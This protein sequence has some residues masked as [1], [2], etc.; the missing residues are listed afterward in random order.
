MYRV[1]INS[2]MTTTPILTAI[3]V[4]EE[5]M[6]GETSQVTSWRDGIH[7]HIHSMEYIYEVLLWK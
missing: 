6:L 5:L 3:T 2:T 4:T 1:E 7:I